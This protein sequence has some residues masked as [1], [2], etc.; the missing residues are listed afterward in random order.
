MANF[1]PSVG[2]TGPGLGLCSTHAPHQL[3]CSLRTLL[4][5]Q[6]P[7]EGCTKAGP[8]QGTALLLQTA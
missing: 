7:R 8:L 5:A 4:E 3:A 6:C 1:S 2:T